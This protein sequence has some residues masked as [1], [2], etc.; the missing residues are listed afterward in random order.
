MLAVASPASAQ[1]PRVVPSDAFGYACPPDTILLHADWCDV[2]WAG[3]HDAVEWQFRFDGGSWSPVNWLCGSW[4]CAALARSSSLLYMYMDFAALHRV[5]ATP[6]AVG[7][8][9]DV[10][11][12]DGQWVKKDA[13]EILDPP[14]GWAETELLIRPGK[15]A[16]LNVAG[17]RH[18]AA[19]SAGWTEMRFDRTTA[20]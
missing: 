13:H 12:D 8:T 3:G 16:D 7:P 10:R 18:R 9:R 11:L 15:L 20:P 5:G 1:Q 6:A 17:L 2:K 4:H 19:G 14:S